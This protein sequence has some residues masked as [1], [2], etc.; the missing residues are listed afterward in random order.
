M[1]QGGQQPYY[2]AAQGA[3]TESMGPQSPQGHY[4]HG[5]AG[6]IPPYYGQPQYA[7]PQPGQGYYAAPHYAQYAGYPPPPPP[8][9]YPYPPDA[10]QAMHQGH[11][12][13]AQ[14]AGQAHGASMSDLMEEVANGG[15][16]LSALSKM[17]NFDDPDFWK[18]AL[19]GAAAVLLLTSESVQNALFK[20]GGGENGNGSKESGS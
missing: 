9:V 10:F 13:D 20:S 16:G 4:M 14:G 5:G 6:A 7:Q 12:H 18:G 3:P 19:V 17:L 8:G 11:A 15:N 2:G 1:S